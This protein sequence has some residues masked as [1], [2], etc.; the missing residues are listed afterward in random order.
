[1]S[2]S[3]LKRQHSLEKFNLRN[4]TQKLCFERM[5]R[6]T[7]IGSKNTFSALTSCGNTVK[8]FASLFLSERQINGG[9][10]HSLLSG[11]IFNQIL[12]NPN[13]SIPY[14][15]LSVSLKLK[16]IFDIEV[17][18]KSWLPTVDLFC[19]KKCSYNVS[20]FLGELLKTEN[21]DLLPKVF[22]CSTSWLSLEKKIKA[23]E[24]LF[25]EMQDHEFIIVKRVCKSGQKY[26][27]QLI[28]GYMNSESELGYTLFEWQKSGHPFSSIYGFSL[29]GFFGH[30]NKFSANARW[31][32]DNHHSMTGI[33]EL[34]FNKNRYL[35][36]FSFRSLEVST[37]KY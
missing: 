21:P 36:A 23:A 19:R 7:R 2:V 29:T 18:R 8:C 15:V 26:E 33:R 31:D 22:F 10:L 14:L 30:L 24:D 1:V 35:P 17:N 3:V 25:Q 11:G 20:S 12:N 32:C 5:I 6:K 9:Y 28:Q 13:V 16:S 37:H 27:Y 4:P 34:K